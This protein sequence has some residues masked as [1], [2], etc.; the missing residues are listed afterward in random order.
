LEKGKVLYSQKGGIKVLDQREKTKTVG[1]KGNW[2]VKPRGKKRK[3]NFKE[4]LRQGEAQNQS[5]KKKDQATPLKGEGK[6][7]KGHKKASQ[8]VQL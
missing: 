2:G 7:Q 1:A 5:T 6:G 4:N 3:E 8:I